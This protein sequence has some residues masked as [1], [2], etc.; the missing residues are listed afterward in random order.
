MRRVER[1]RVVVRSR[2]FPNIAPHGDDQDNTEAIQQS[3][4]ASKPTSSEVCLPRA[5]LLSQS[6]AL[7]EVVRRETRRIFPKTR[8]SAGPRESAEPRLFIH[9]EQRPT[10]WPERLWTAVY[11]YRLSCGAQCEFL[12]SWVYL[13]RAF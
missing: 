9:R 12:L 13:E 4:C 5:L 10:A 1:L 2:H 11:R 7:C 8:E 6:P 3:Q